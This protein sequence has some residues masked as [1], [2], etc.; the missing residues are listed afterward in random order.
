[1]NKYWKDALK[2]LLSLEIVIL[3]CLALLW[4]ACFLTPIDGGS[5]Y[6]V[7]WLAFKFLHPAIVVVWL[8]IL[9]LD[10]LNF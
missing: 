9:A 4:F 5:D 10:K 2:A 6:S 3:A 8:T 7:F 1:M